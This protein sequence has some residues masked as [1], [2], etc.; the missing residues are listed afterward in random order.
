MISGNKLFW[1]LPLL[2]LIP[3]HKT[4]TMNFFFNSATKRK[5]FF[6]EKISISMLVSPQTALQLLSGFLIFHQNF[7]HSSL[8]LKNNIVKEKMILHRVN[9]T[10]HSFFIPST[11]MFD[12]VWILKHSPSNWS[13]EFTIHIHIHFCSFP[14]QS[15][16]CLEQGRK[17]YSCEW[18][19][20]KCSFAVF[21]SF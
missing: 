14:D 15:I 17:T 19:V 8:L 16:C 5:H 2:V 18:V 21:S 20:F 9:L 12:S 13:I 10:L 11:F 3:F 1:K 7:Q 4:L 6:S